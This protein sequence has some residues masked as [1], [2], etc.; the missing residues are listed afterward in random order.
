MT[1]TQVNGYFLRLSFPIILKTGGKGVPESR[2][3]REWG[4][5]PR[6]L[7]FTITKITSAKFHDSAQTYTAGDSP[8]A[9]FQ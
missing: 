1:A 5:S 2:L 9:L 6:H 3:W 4:Q 8:Q 7:A